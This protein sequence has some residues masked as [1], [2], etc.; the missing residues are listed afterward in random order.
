MKKVNLPFAGLLFVA[1]LCSCSSE[2][3]PETFN[4]NTKGAPANT[5]LGGIVA[6]NKSNPIDFA[7]ESYRSTLSEYQSGN[8]SPDSLAAVINLVNS[9]TGTVTLTTTAVDDTTE[10]LLTASIQSPKATLVVILQQSSLSTEAREVLTDFVEGFDSL[11]AKPFEEIYPEIV[12][13]EN[14]IS[15]SD[16]LTATDKN[17]LLTVTSIARH[18]LS[19]KCCED[20]DWETSVGNIV[21]AT[22]GA[23][24]STDLAVRYTLITRIGEYELVPL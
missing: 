23:L 3:S 15:G 9:L 10:T 8:Y 7:G 6:G 22:A 21:A 20:T 12:S 17:V 2:D 1:L 24:V 19:N 18:S 14:T 4:I 11:K 5:R 16:S 13:L